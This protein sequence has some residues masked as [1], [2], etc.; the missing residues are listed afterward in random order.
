[1]LLEGQM[2]IEAE[3]MGAASP[4]LSGSHNP[5]STTS[6]D[7]KI[8]RHHL[9]REFLGDLVLTFGGRSARRPEYTNLAKLAV[10]R[11]HLGCVTHFLQ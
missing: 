8:L 11:K 1:M 4:L 7:H 9:P 6:D 3:A 2:D 5:V 10:S